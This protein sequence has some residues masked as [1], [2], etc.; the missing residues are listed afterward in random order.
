MVIIKFMRTWFVKDWYDYDSPVRCF[1]YISIQYSG[2]ICS[3][4]MWVSVAAYKVSFHAF[5]LIF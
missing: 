1:F 4:A 2:S 5:Y 3:V